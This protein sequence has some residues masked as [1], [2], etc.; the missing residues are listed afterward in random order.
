LDDFVVQKTKELG[1]RNVIHGC[2]QHT[3]G[4]GHNKKLRG[5]GKMIILN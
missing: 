2:F 5:E 3:K 1:T 4:K